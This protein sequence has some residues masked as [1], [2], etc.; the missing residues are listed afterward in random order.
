MFDTT[1]LTLK[2]LLEQ[3]DCG[4]LQLPEFQ[5]DYVWSEEAV[6]SLLASV[7]KGAPSTWLPAGLRDA[8]ELG[9]RAG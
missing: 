4:T 5:R 6:V 8:A 1:K 7:A 9:R 2:K 3:V